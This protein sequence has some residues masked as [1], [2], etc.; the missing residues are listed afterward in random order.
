MVVP[1]R[2]VYSVSSFTKD[3]I[4]QYH[5][6]TA[7]YEKKGYDLFS[8]GVSST[9]KSIAHQHT[10]LIKT[11]GK[12]IKGLIYIEKPLVHKILL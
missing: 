4:A 1:K 12:K 5:K 9:M 2:H 11:D 6:I 10:H 3:E 8:R 7:Q